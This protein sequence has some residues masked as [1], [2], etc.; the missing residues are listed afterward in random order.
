[1]LK[2]N[3]KY[4][5]E[6]FWAKQLDTE[7]PEDHWEKTIRL[8][9]E[10]DFSVSST[11]LRVSNFITSFANKKLGDKLSKQKVLEVT[12]KI[13]QIQT[14]TYDR[15][16]EKI[17]KPVALISNRAETIIE[18]P[19]NKTTYTYKHG[20]RPKK[21]PQKNLQIFQ[22]TKVKSQPQKSNS[23]VEMPCLSKQEEKRGEFVDLN[24]GVSQE[25]K[26]LRNPN[27]QKKVIPTIRQTD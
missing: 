26:R 5:R 14:K 3:Q 7:T 27:S 10:C 6:F 16:N 9:K 18:Q 23:R 20:I 12:K 2:R 15:K 22:R 24:T 11:K 21:R 25:I 17:T 4:S 8:E 13:E 1:M 19:I